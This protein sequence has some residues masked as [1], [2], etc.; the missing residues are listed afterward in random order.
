M[1][2]MLDKARESW[3][4]AETFRASEIYLNI[5]ANRYYYAL[6]QILDGFNAS[7]KGKDIKRRH[8]QTAHVFMR[9]VARES[10]PSGKGYLLSALDELKSLRVQADYYPDQIE[11]QDL[12]ECLVDEAKMLFKLFEEKIIGEQNG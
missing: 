4:F 12:D 5:V 9:I 11:L 6:Y 1:S 10:L 7:P 8:D 2:T 3:E